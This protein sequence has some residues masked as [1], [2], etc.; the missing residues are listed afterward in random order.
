[1][2]INAKIPNLK[3]DKPKLDANYNLSLKEIFIKFQ[4]NKEEKFINNN[5]KV[6]E[7][8]RENELKL[9]DNSYIT[10]KA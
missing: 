3:L 1:M 2:D 8:I 10:V 4:D 9:K 6:I 5:K 7:Y